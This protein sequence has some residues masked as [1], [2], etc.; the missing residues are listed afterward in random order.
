MKLVV[1]STG[2]SGIQYGIS[3]LKQLQG[4]SVEVPH[5]STSAQ[6]VMETET[7]LAT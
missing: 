2:G 7:R 5:S 4:T 6:H 3:L 1:G